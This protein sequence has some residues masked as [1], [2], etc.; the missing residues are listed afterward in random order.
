MAIFTRQATYE[1]R[2]GSIGGILEFSPTGKYLA[3]SDDVGRGVR[4]VDCT[5]RPSTSLLM[6]M[7]GIPSSFVWDPVQPDKFVVGF[8]DGTLASFAKGRAETR[9]HFLHDQ[10]PITALALN[11]DST[12]LAVVV[13][14]DSIFV[15]RRESLAGEATIPLRTRA[16]TQRLPRRV[17][18]RSRGGFS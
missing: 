10:G 1:L 13:D 2:P 18:V 12:I 16:I 4:I 14:M 15:F 11:N 7:P 3:I 6:D 17:R 9:V 5:Q 8:A